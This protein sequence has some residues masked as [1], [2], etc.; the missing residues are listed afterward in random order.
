MREWRLALAQ[1]TEMGNEDGSRGFPGLHHSFNPMRVGLL[2]LP[3]LLETVRR[4][5]ER[6]LGR[7]PYQL[8][9][10]VLVQELEIIYKDEGC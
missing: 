4:R 10:L 5:E 3:C 9:Y 7:V 8:E 1:D 6:F 2:C